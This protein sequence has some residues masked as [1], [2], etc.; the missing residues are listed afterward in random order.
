MANVAN[1]LPDLRED[2]E[3]GRER[4]GAELQFRGVSMLSVGA[5][6]GEKDVSGGGRRT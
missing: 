1:D 2:E 3:E 6:R 5:G 4:G